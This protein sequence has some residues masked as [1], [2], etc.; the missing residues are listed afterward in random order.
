MV[1]LNIVLYKF[2]IRYK[3]ACYKALTY[4]LASRRFMPFRPR[5]KRG[6]GGNSL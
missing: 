6:R 2:Y 3:L 5:F 1:C 4:A